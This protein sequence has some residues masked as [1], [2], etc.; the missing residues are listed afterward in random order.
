[1]PC[2]PAGLCVC[3]ASPA[4]STRPARYWSATRSWIRNLDPQITSVTL[5]VVR[6]GPR[7]VSSRRAKETARGSRAPSASATRRDDPPRGAGPTGV[8]QSLR[9]SDVRLLRRIVDFGNEPERPVRERRHDQHA[10]FGEEEQNLIPWQ[11]ALHPDISQRE[12]QRQRIVAVEP[13]SGQV[14]D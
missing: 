1:M 5:T 14:A 6:R 8:E 10:R 3:A 2:P 7:G 9:K 13:E 12:R 4:S 11:A